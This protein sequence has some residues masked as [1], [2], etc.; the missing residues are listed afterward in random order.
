V[1]SSDLQADFDVVM[2]DYV[3]THLGDPD[4]VLRNFYDAL[5]SGGYALLEFTSINDPHCGQGKK[6]GKNQY[7]QDGTYIRFFTLEEIES[8]MYKCNFNVLFIDSAWSTDPGHGA[9]YTRR[10]RHKHHSF[11]VIAKKGDESN[12]SSERT[13]LRMMEPDSPWKDAR[14]R[15]LISQYSGP[16]D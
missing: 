6:A 10:K 8:R 15:A 16:E 9:G 7:V 13:A 3:I 2:C 11:F 14:T 1:C 12:R 4:K 5:R